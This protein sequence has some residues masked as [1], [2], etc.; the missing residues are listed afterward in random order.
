MRLPAATRLLNALPDAVTAAFFLTLWIAPLTLGR[1]AVRTALLIMLVEFMLVHASAFL[2]A[3]AFAEGVT[4]LRK[5]A[6]LA[7]FGVFYLIFIAVW[8]WM[9]GQ[10]WPFLAFGWLLLGKMA[11]AVDPGASDLDRRHRMQSGWAI[12]TMAYL[13]G[14]FVTVFVPLPRLGITPAVVARLDLPGGGLWV[15]RPH[16]VVAFGALYFG[17]LAW[18]KAR[19]LR[20]PAT[21]LPGITRSS[22]QAR[23]R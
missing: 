17:L 18:T 10:W 23:E 1:H 19:D 8:S 3:A 14:A 4:R 20:L 22:A 9:F 5:L 6:V 21:H 2:G 15:D 11:V 16:T 12:A 13:A 7:G